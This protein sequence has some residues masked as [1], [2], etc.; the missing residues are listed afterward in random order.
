MFLLF[1]QQWVLAT[2]QTGHIGISHHPKFVFHSPCGGAASLASKTVSLG[3]RCFY[4]ML[5]TWRCNS[6]ERPWK[7]RTGLGVPLLL[8]CDVSAASYVFFSY[9]YFYPFKANSLS[10]G[11]GVLS[12]EASEKA[13]W[14][15]QAL[16]PLSRRFGL[17]EQVWA[18]LADKRYEMTHT[19]RESRSVP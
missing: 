5:S 18:L 2:V 1:C 14:A 13:E 15:H 16:S 6:D 12:K 4:G 19:G 9:R 7:S 11:W 10:S 17:S 8:V 3:P